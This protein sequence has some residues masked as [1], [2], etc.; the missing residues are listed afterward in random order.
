MQEALQLHQEEVVEGL[1]VMRLLA[2]VQEL[3]QQ[4]VEGVV[5]LEVVAYQEV[6]AMVKGEHLLICSFFDVAR[7][8]L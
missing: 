6:E 1:E 7:T 2:T 8:H 4:G 5:P 3:A